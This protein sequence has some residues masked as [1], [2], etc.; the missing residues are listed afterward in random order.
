MTMKLFHIFVGL[1]VLSLFLIGCTAP[2][3]PKVI[4][5]EPKEGVPAPTVPETAE[6]TSPR[7]SMIDPVTVEITRSGFNQKLVRVTAGQKVIFVNKDTVDHWPAS[8][9]HPIHT[10]YPGSRIT[11]CGSAEQAHIFDAC[12][13]V[14]PGGRWEFI[15]IETGEWAFHDH[16]NPSFTGTVIVR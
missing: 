1:I 16:F 5:E 11:K 3:T 10:G 14:A 4:P 6:E 2:E 8:G 12:A 13:G 15:F 9:P 7:D